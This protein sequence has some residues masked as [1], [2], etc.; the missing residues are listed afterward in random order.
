VS[1][2]A[3]KRTSYDTGD[4]R[5][6]RDALRAEQHGV[7]VDGDLFTSDAAGVLIKSGTHI[8][9]LGGPYNATTEEIQT[10]TEGGSGLTSFTLTF[11]GQTTTSLDDQATAAQVQAALEAL[12]NIGE[13]NVEVTG[14]AGGVYTVK[15]V[16]D[17]ANTNVA[18]MTATPTGGTG[19]VTIATSTAGGAAVDSPSGSGKTEGHLRNDLVVKPG[20]KHL[21]PSSTRH[22]RPALPA[23]HRQPRRCS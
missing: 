1:N 11:S 4:S 9:E 10:I 23:R 6:L 7:T 3:P 21:S 20:E 18:Q 14:N 12:S 19:T 16:N 17:L 15:F 22:G 13:G 2:F 8:S 5:W